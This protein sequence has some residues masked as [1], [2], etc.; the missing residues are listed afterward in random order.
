MTDGAGHLVGPV[1]QDWVLAGVLRTAI[2]FG[3]VGQLLGAVLVD[4]HTD[5]L[6]SLKTGVYPKSNIEKY[7]LHSSYT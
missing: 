6:F 2:T 1:Q 7:C 5:L 3:A 4:D